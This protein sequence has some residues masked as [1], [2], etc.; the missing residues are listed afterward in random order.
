MI[1]SVFAWEG[2]LILDIC[3]FRVFAKTTFL[4]KRSYQKS[5]FGSELPPFVWPCV[6]L[7]IAR[8]TTIKRKNSWVEAR[9][10]R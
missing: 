7:G 5:M 3:G 1:F 8:I 10:K 2:V 9:E 4:I 6:F